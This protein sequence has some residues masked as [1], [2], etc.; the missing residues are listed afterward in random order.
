MIKTV[1]FILGAAVVLSACGSTANNS[2]NAIP[3][4]VATNANV[5]KLDPAN[6]PPGLSGSPLPV[7]GVPG[8]PSNG[9]A[10]LPKGGT[11]T[12]GIPG[13]EEIK[14]GIK[15]GLTPT[16]G[17][18]DPATIRKQMGLPPLNMNAVPPGGSSTPVPK[19]KKTTGGRPQ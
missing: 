6:M 7:N 19:S 13:P 3:P 10:V 14:K 9:A 11:P 15:P 2:T 17:I 4:S 16:P 18:P 5:I 8:I 1:G 12:P